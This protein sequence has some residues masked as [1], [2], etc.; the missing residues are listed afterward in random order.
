MLPA[1]LWR[2]DLKFGKLKENC[3]T[4]FILQ[5]SAVS[6]FSSDE[7]GK[8]STI[9]FHQIKLRGISFKFGFLIE[10]QIVSWFDWE[11]KAKSVKFS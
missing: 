10:F 2:Q 6:W 3:E 1:G 11:F 5:Q 8:K 7:Y 4:F 9:I